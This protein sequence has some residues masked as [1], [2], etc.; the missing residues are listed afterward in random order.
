MQILADSKHY[1][2]DIV[3]IVNVIKLSEESQLQLFY[4]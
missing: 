4:E 2:I 1:N 3:N